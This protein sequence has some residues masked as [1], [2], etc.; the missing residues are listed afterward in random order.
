[1]TAD[2]QTSS[3]ERVPAQTNPSAMEALPVRALGHP[4]RTAAGALV[5]VALTLLAFSI[6]TNR[7][8]D[9]RVVGQFLFSDVILEGVLKTLALTIMAMTIAS[10]L[11][12]PLALSRLSQSRIL[13]SYAS[14]Y[15]WIFRG[16]PVLVQ[17][18]FWF[19]LALV[20]PTIGID[21][22][23]TSLSF[24]VA[25]NDVMTPFLT[26]LVGLSLNEAAYMAEIV[27]GGLLSVDSGQTEAAL[28]LGM[29]ERRTV[30]RIVLPQAMRAILPPAGNELITCLK[31]TALVSIISYHELL[32]TT[33][34]IYSVNYRTVELLVVASFW[35]LAC[36]TLINVIQHFVE[37]RFARGFV[38]TTP[39]VSIIRRAMTGWRLRQS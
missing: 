15:I 4:L 33:Q 39:R 27:R 20:F 10:L 23:G 2:G 9:F 21:I 37:E 8:F 22:P 26:A 31:T 12:L 5:L 29:T 19:N 6:A 18:I 1:M 24:R 32:G 35:Y 36:T 38:K 17:L 3:P 7:N 16:T 28:A 13:R 25:T 14:A 11:A 30:R 34:G